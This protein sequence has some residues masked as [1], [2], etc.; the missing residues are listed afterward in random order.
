MVY[1]RT[2]ARNNT[3]VPTL[4][5]YEYDALIVCLAGVYPLVTTYGVCIYLVSGTWYLVYIARVSDEHCK[6]AVRLPAVVY[7]VPGSPC[8]TA[9]NW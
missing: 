6:T 3:S 5:L 8:V 2:L 9:H 7:L 1:P 4:I